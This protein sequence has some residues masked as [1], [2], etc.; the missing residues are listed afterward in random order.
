MEQRAVE[1][2][3]LVDVAYSI[4][5]VPLALF[6]FTEIDVEALRTPSV[7]ETCNENELDDP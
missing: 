1:P 4:S 6:T 5:Q 2:A 7:T 3:R